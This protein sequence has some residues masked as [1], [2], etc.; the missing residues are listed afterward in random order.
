MFGVPKK[1]SGG[2]VSAAKP[3]SHRGQGVTTKEKDVVRD[4][5]EKEPERRALLSYVGWPV[6][7]E[8]LVFTW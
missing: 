8:I 7:F 6:S 3:L 5:K 1:F 2:T 4:M